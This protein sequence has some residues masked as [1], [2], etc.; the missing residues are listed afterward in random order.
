MTLCAFKTKYCNFCYLLSAMTAGIL[1][2]STCSDNLEVPTMSKPFL[3]VPV[4]SSLDRNGPDLILFLRDYIR[5]YN[6]YDQRLNMLRIYIFVP[7]TRPILRI[8]V[9]TSLREDDYPC[10]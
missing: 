9:V 2:P 1:K 6:Y 5:L 4:I 8:V 3:G 10:T 7:N